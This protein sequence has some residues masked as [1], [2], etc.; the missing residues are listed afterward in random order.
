L[1]LEPGTTVADGLQLL[2]RRAS[3]KYFGEPDIQVGRTLFIVPDAVANLA[4][5]WIKGA[6]SFKQALSLLTHLPSLKKFV[7]IHSWKSCHSVS[8]IE[9]SFITLRLGIVLILVSVNLH[10]YNKEKTLTSEVLLKGRLNTGDLLVLASLD[11]FILKLK[12]LVSFFTKQ[13]TLTKRSTVLILLPP[14]WH[15]LR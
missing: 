10:V 6:Q 15:T 4:F 11:Q 9:K 1:L 3:I 13:A 8:D 5:G 12:I 2:I 14:G 7:D